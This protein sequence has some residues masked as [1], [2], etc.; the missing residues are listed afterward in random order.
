MT[1]LFALAGAVFALPCLAFAEGY[2]HK[3]RFVFIGPPRPIAFFSMLAMGALC[4][5]CAGKPLGFL[6]APICLLLGM[7]A[8]IDLRCGLLPDLLVLFLLLLA[9]LHAALAGFQDGL[10]GLLTG[11]GSYGFF[12]VLG[13]LLFKKEALGLGDVKLMAACGLWLGFERGLASVALA[14]VLAAFALIALLVSRRIQRNARFPFGPFIAA[15]CLLSY[16]LAGGWLS[17]YTRALF[18]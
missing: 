2:I 14:P 9:L 13:L 10:F 6:A 3:R 15:A 17:A 12:Y 4:A 11:G 18:Y 7:L 8:Y 1:M 16:F 5:V